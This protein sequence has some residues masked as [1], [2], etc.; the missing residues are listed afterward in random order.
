MRPDRARLAR[1]RRALALAGV[2]QTTLARASGTSKSTVSYVLHGKG[3]SERLITYA[4]A[5]VKHPPPRPTAQ[6]CPHCF[7]MGVLPPPFRSRPRAD[8]RPGE[9]RSR[10][11]PP[12]ESEP[13]VVSNPEPESEPVVGRHPEPEERPLTV[14]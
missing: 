5:L 8:L 14:T 4:E 13:V 11:H 12:H 3:T 10:R 1:L 7:G 6:A 2:T 9:P